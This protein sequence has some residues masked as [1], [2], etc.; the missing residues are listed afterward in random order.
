MKKIIL[1][2]VIAASANG[3]TLMEVAPGGPFAFSGPPIGFKAAQAV[4]FSLDKAYTN[5]TIEAAIG[6]TA[7][8]P[9]GQA[10]LTTA[11]GP[12][13]TQS[14]E[15]HSTAVNYP[16]ANIGSLP[17]MTIFSGLSLGAGDYFLVFETPQTTASNIAGWGLGNAVSTANGIT[18]LGSFG[19]VPS[20][21]YA[22]SSSFGQVT[23]T[24]HRFRVTGDAAV[25]EPATLALTGFALL[26]IGFIRR[27]S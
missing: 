20:A 6:G 19:R 25:P 1:A 14:N 21:A 24:H 15:L 22:P 8:F 16:V 13:A 5:I 2:L 11:I 9:A 10:Y 3:A 12:A 4:G 7:A 26:T 17:L 18:F 27:R 23:D